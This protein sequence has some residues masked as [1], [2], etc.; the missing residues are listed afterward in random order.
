MV[1]KLEEDHGVFVVPVTVN[2]NMNLKF[3]VDSGASDVTIPA[4]AVAALM[5]SGT[6]SRSDFMGEG[7]AVLADGSK[8]KIQAFRLRSLRLGNLL[9]ENVTASVSP[10]NAP[11]LLGQSF[12]NRLK[13][14]SLDNATHTLIVK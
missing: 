10:A 12:L 14:W 11:P 1:I 4:D 13:S 3:I 8:T 2:G 6:V 5:S 9:L 7:I